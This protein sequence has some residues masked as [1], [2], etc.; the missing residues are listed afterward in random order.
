MGD[1]YLK[2][3]GPDRTGRYSGHR[4]PPK[5]RWTPTIET[6]EMCESGWHLCRW[7]DTSHWIN[8]TLWVVEADTGGML[9]GDD[10]VVVRRARLL[11][12]VV[13]WDERTRLLYAADC[14]DRVLPLFEAKHPDDDRPRRAVEAVRAFAHGLIGV[15]ELADAEAAA[16][17]AHAAY[18][19]KAADFVVVAAA[20]AAARG[21]R[22]AHASYADAAATYATYATA[23]DADA[24]RRWQADHLGELCGLDSDDFAHRGGP[25]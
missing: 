24:E 16:Y 10:K 14:A 1:L 6:L 19:V 25:R 9:E 2:F 8:A 12:Q 7:E 5:R 15:T 18:A 17:A 23:A 20:Y 13:A 21:A 4:W 3:L 22:A 11:D